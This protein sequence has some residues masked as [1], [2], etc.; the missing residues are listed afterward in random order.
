[1]ILDEV[2]YLARAA[3]RMVERFAALRPHSLRESHRG[4]KLYKAARGRA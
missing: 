3:N 2:K 4:L 1:M